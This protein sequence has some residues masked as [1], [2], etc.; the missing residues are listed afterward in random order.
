[1]EISFWDWPGEGVP[2]LFAHATGFH[3]RCWDEIIRRLP[4][5]RCVA[6][7]FR[8]HGRSDKPEPPYHWRAF[9]RDLAAVA[10]KLQLRGAIGVGH[11]MGGHSI[12]ACAIERPETFSSLLL[13]DATIFKREYYGAPR[14]D[15]SSFIRRRR[16]VWKS[17][18]EMFERFHQRA[19]FD[20]WQPQILRDYCEYGL[21]RAGDGLVLACPP[22]V[23]ASIYEHSNAPESDLYPWIPS[24]TAPVTVMRAEREWR[25]DVFDLTASPT[26]PDLATR[27]ANGRAVPLAG[28]SHYIPMEDPELEAETVR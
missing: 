14:R 15:D 8:G 18:D 5:R 23:E 1:V 10:E 16:N 28:R 7:D 26:A 9:G 19:P 24:V 20:S 3:G 6:I 17:A 25:T 11:S 2:V 13:V 21:L 12:V 27:F 22:D 4:G